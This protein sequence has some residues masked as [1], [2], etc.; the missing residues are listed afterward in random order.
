MSQAS[1]AIA[2]M[3]LRS[4]VMLNTQKETLRRGLE[5]VQRDIE[6]LIE[7]GAGSDTLRGREAMDAAHA[8]IVSV[9]KQE[10]LSR[11]LEQAVNPDDRAHL[12]CKIME[13]RYGV[14]LSFG[15]IGNVT[16]TYD[17][18]SYRFFTPWRDEPGSQGRSISF[19][20]C[21]ADGVSELVD[22]AEEHFEAW[23]VQT[24]CQYGNTTTVSDQPIKE[25]ALADWINAQVTSSTGKWHYRLQR[26]YEGRWT[27]VGNDPNWMNDM[28]T[29]AAN[30]RGPV[31]DRAALLLLRR[32]NPDQYWRL[33]LLVERGV[34]VEVAPDGQSAQVMR[35]NVP[36]PLFGASGGDLECNLRSALYS[37]AKQLFT[38]NERKNATCFSVRNKTPSMG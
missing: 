15:Y 13:E 17:D 12:L 20:S 11:D 30:W 6:A 21:S 33:R 2:T 1:N 8:R 23:L 4:A 34:T 27:L 14:K 16:S 25:E 37:A 10:R 5:A 7:L 3:P 18:R 35:E 36:E 28:F 38:E 31:G 26:S 9:L 19:G 22:H 24:A 32:D 29:R